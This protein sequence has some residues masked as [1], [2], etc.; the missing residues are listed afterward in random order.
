MSYGHAMSSDESTVRRRAQTRWSTADLRF[1][2]L[3]DTLGP[4]VKAGYN[5]DARALARVRLR[6]AHGPACRSVS[7]AHPNRL[8]NLAR[9]V[10]ALPP[11]TAA[12]K[13]IA[14]WGDLFE[15]LL[16]SHL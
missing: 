4:A 6:P 13:G 10:A 2:L 8:R 11:Q 1:G 16:Q 15:T 5:D 3:S 14:G 7:S 9:A 12:Y